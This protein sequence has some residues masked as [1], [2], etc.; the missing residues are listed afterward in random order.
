MLMITLISLLV[1]FFFLMIRRPPRSTLF[2]YTTL[3]RAPGPGRARAAPERP[4]R[5]ARPPD[6]PGPVPRPRSARRARGC[7]PRARRAALPGR[8]APRSGPRASPPPRSASLPPPSGTLR[9]RGPASS[10]VPVVH[11]LTVA[12]MVVEPGRVQVQVDRGDAGHGVEDGMADPL[13]ERVGVAQGQV[14]IDVG[15]DHDVQGAADPAG[16]DRVRSEE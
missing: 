9:P 4:R 6:A 1:F 5:P 10:P 2:P 3:F 16:T 14:R 13:A 12:V 11:R 7:P 15:V 8:R